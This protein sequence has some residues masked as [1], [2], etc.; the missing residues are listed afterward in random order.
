MEGQSFEAF[1]SDKGEPIEGVFVAGWSREA[2][3]GLVGL[4]RKDGV[5]GANAVLQYLQTITD[6]SPDVLKHLQGVLSGLP[7]PTIS[8]DHLKLLVKSEETRRI[9]L[10]VQ[11]FKF[12]NNEEMLT[13]MGLG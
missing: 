10:G 2:S 4:A 5:N 12:D 3:R 6:G 8:R 9:Q 13:E 7:H 1:D 11:D